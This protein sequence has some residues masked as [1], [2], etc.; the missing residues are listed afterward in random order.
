MIKS[1][2][3]LAGVWHWG[4]LQSWEEFGGTELGGRRMTEPGC[5]HGPRRDG[6]AGVTWAGVLPASGFEGGPILL[7][8]WGMGG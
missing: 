3:T 5:C 6:R 1:N 7:G 2:N 4:D 8:R